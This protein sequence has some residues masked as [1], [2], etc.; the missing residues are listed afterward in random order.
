MNV[1]KMSLAGLQRTPVVDRVKDLARSLKEIL[2]SVFT[3]HEEFF[4]SIEQD[5]IPG[6]MRL[7]QAEKISWRFNFKKAEPKNLYFQRICNEYFC[8]TVDFFFG[9]PKFGIDNLKALARA[10]ACLGSGCLLLYVPNLP[11]DPGLLP[12][13]RKDFC[14]HTKDRYKQK[15]DDI[16]QAERTIFQTYNS[17]HCQSYQNIIDSLG[18]EPIVRKVYR[19]TNA[20]TMSLEDIYVLVLELLGQF[21]RSCLYNFDCLREPVLLDRIQMLVE[22]LSKPST[23]YHDIKNPI[24]AFLNCLSVGCH[25]ASNIGSNNLNTSCTSAVIQQIPF[26]ISNPEDWRLYKGLLELKND[27]ESSEKMVL[28]LCSIALHMN[29]MHLTEYPAWI[30]DDTLRLYNRVYYHWRTLLADEQEHDQK[31]RLD[32]YYFRSKTSSDTDKN[33]HNSKETLTISDSK[34]S[35]CSENT[36]ELSEKL[37]VTLADVHHL[38]FGEEQSVENCMKCLINQALR[39]IVQDSSQQLQF[40][41]TEKL[42][43]G[44]HTLILLYLHSIQRPE[45]SYIAHDYAYDFNETPNLC[46][47]LKFQKLLRSIQ[48]SILNENKE[49]TEDGNVLEILDICR[50]ALSIRVEDPLS[51]FLQMSER[52]YFALS[53]WDKL[54]SKHLNI[55]TLELA[56]LIYRWRNLEVQSWKTIL[57]AEDRRC[58]ASAKRWWFVMYESIIIGTYRACEENNLKEYRKKLVVIVEDFFSSASSGQFQQRLT[59]IKAFSKHLLLLAETKPIVLSIYEAVASVLDYFAR[60]EVEIRSSI[61]NTNKSLAKD[62]GEVVR[63][64]TLKD[65]DVRKLRESAHSSWK[66]ILKLKKIYQELLDQPTDLSFNRRLP[67]I[68]TETNSNIST[69]NV[70]LSFGHLHLA[71]LSIPG[72]DQRREP[73]N[74]ILSTVKA[75]SLVVDMNSVIVQCTKNVADMRLSLQNLSQD[76]SEQVVKKPP[77]LSRYVIQKKRQLF[78]DVKR[79]LRELGFDYRVREDAPKSQISTVEILASLPS[80]PNVSFGN[81]PLAREYFYGFIQEMPNVRKLQQHHTQNLAHSEVI[82]FTEYTEN[83]LKFL[84]DQRNGLLIVLKSFLNV[85]SIILKIRPYLI[86]EA[87]SAHESGIFIY[88]RSSLRDKIKILPALITLSID[89]LRAQDQGTE[90]DVRKIENFMLKWQGV[91]QLAYRKICNIPPIVYGLGSET[92]KKVCE[93]IEASLLQFVQDLHSWRRPYPAFTHIVEKLILW[94]TQPYDIKT[95]SDLFNASDVH[96]MS[97]NF[98]DLLDLMLGSIQDVKTCIAETETSVESNNWLYSV[99]KDAKKILHVFKFNSIEQQLTRILRYKTGAKKPHKD[100]VS[101]MNGLFKSLG[102][103]IEQYR[104]ISISFISRYTDLHGALCYYSY[105]IITTFKEICREE[106]WVSNEEGTKETFLDETKGDKVGLGEGT[107]AENADNSIEDGK[108]VADFDNLENQND[109]TDD[110]LEEDALELGEDS[111]LGNVRDNVTHDTT[112]EENL[113]DEK[114]EIEEKIEQTGQ[115]AEDEKLWDK[116]DM[117]EDSQAKIGQGLSAG[118]AAARETA[119]SMSEPLQTQGKQ[120]LKKQSKA[121]MAST[122]SERERIEETIILDDQESADLTDEYDSH[123]GQTDVMENEDIDSAFEDYSKTHSPSASNIEETNGADSSTLH[124]ENLSEA[125]NIVDIDS[126]E[127]KSPLLENFDLDQAEGGEAD[128]IKQSNDRAE[129]SKDLTVRPDVAESEINQQAWKEQRTRELGSIGTGQKQRQ[130][131]RDK[132]IMEDDPDFSAYQRNDNIDDDPSS[133]K[134]MNHQLTVWKALGSELEEW[135][136]S[137]VD[138]AQERSAEQQNIDIEMADMQSNIYKDNFLE[139]QALLRPENGMTLDAQDGEEQTQSES[140]TDVF[141]KERYY[142]SI[143][144]PEQGNAVKKLPLSKEAI[145][146][147]SKYAQDIKISKYERSKLLNRDETKDDYQNISTVKLWDNDRSILSHSEKSGEVSTNENIYQDLSQ[148]LA[149]QLRLILEPTKSTKF[150]GDF[151]TGKKLNIRRIIPYIAS[152]GKRDKIWM[153]RTV[154]SKRAYQIMLALDDS[155]SMI[156]SDSVSPA[157]QSLALISK[158]LAIVEAGELCVVAFGEDCRIALDFGTPFVHETQN[159]FRKSFTFTQSRT[160][161]RALIEATI[162]HFR[163]ARSKA[164]YSESHL[165]QLQ[166]IISDGICEEHEAIKKLVSQAEQERIM[167]VFI[168]M[169]FG[170]QATEVGQDVSQ[171]SILDLQTATFTS[172]AENN[173]VVKRQYYMDTFPFKWYLLVRNI[174][175]LPFALTTALR[176]WFAEV[177]FYDN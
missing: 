154:P 124:S 101:C 62:F 126:C 53:D 38:M 80:L 157:L 17:L 85:E 153:R 94:T 138:I 92:G 144:A 103:I 71:D 11:M 78:N 35:S 58:S 65:R 49:Q 116:G 111:E 167:I 174:K 161:I 132:Q 7:S 114:R 170:T 147:A 4:E 133:Q 120:E 119:E 125:S 55:Y 123:V 171:R 77:K 90:Y 97:Q 3:L 70:N 100:I 37:S 40:N 20:E 141:A 61:S 128:L 159:L 137:Q 6:V 12:L 112:V 74:D 140:V 109:I 1:M 72:S 54:R 176:Q 102:P 51:V 118:S 69:D 56:R 79:S 106:F 86:N 34:G 76:I 99:D 164:A 169:D 14:V 29:T 24:V 66:K 63:I 50:Q 45:R 127:G 43:K 149:E 73:Y 163:K 82:Q 36:K 9:E 47:A 165:W 105:F 64:A 158:A 21:E 91:F 31:R 98:F 27:R 23:A 113:N 166:L 5:G 75:M 13:L 121:D 32:M 68:V 88:E 8:N 19:P 30:E 139:E 33:S 151:R 28:A 25:L 117:E 150:R 148:V 81:E 155:K 59:M 10:W 134:N 122:K 60:Y 160:D 145:Q 115:S 46:E 2:C 129:E 26:L 104:R 89:V 143:I 177:T 16:S 44:L 95:E 84:A 48:L 172:D 57:D 41:I 136:T 131:T 42:D 110:M 152:G 168:I 18:P 108:D 146:N 52:L 93:D 83:L 39:T 87:F 130:S 156:E 22:R 162:A 135:V 142:E 15:L 107:G 175:D 96:A 67:H 173:I